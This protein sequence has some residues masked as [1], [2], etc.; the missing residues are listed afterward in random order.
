MYRF[1]D[2]VMTN[3]LFLILSLAVFAYSYG[4]LYFGISMTEE[5]KN[6]LIL[7]LLGSVLVGGVTA[8]NIVLLYLF[9]GI[10]LLLKRIIKKYKE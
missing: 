9:K 2:Q 1:K 6:V 8:L 7:S 5:G 10:E 4:A 3:V